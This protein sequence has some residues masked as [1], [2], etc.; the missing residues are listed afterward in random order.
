MSFS[1][2]IWR[3]QTPETPL[4]IA[5]H[6][7]HQQW[8]LTAWP[9]LWPLAKV[10]CVDLIPPTMKAFCSASSSLMDLG[11]LCTL[12]A[13]SFLVIALWPNLVLSV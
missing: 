4:S 2:R 6:R 7:R 10:G 1:L 11:Y 3:S 8:N 9:G 12:G 5:C 13:S